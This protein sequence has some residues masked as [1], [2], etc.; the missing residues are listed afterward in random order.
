MQYIGADAGGIAGG[1]TDYW[2]GKIDSCLNNGDISVNSIAINPQSGGIMGN[3][4]ETLNCFNSG[5]IV[6][7]FN[8]NGKNTY[9]ACGG[10]C[11]QAFMAV[12]NCFSIGTVSVESDGIDDRCGVI[13]GLF[14]G[15]LNI[16][17]CY[18]IACGD[19]KY[20]SAAKEKSD[21]PFI[22]CEDGEEF[23]LSTDEVKNKVLQ[24]C[25]DI[26]TEK[27]GKIVLREM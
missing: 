13:V 25:S 12:E 6:C 14:D 26:Y 15:V 8:E 21:G 19:T 1:K 9:R 24:D 20:C 11:G 16:R 27:N 2:V 23:L 7:E 10:I 18:G 3:G 22:T 17:E 4:G 5:D